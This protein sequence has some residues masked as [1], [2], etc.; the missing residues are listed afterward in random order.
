MRS[1]RSIMAAAAIVVL[2]VGGG[3]F[4]A[5]GYYA[6]CGDRHGLTYGWVGETRST[7]EAAERDA[8]AHERQ[9]GHSTSVVSE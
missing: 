2:L 8:D 3:S 1:K 7:Y 6:I 4:A 9:Y 5:N